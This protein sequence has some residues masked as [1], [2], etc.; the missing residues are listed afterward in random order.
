MVWAILLCWA[1]LVLP[2][3]ADTAFFYRITRDQPLVEALQWIEHSSAKNSLQIL[4]TRPVRI[5]FKNMRELGHGYKDYDA[6]AYI[7]NEGQLLLFINEKHRQ[8]PPQ[9]LA[10]LMSHELLH[11][12]T[13]NSIQEEV[14]AWQQEGQTWQEMLQQC[15]ELQKIPLRQHPLVDRLNAIMALQQHQ[16]L[17]K[18]V[19]T[20]MAYQTLPPHSPGY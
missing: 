8:A 20:H 3:F 2:V 6:L 1:G 16:Q 10:A 12:D 13:E 14:I 4:Q 17:E 15:P 19:Q 11:N 7:S 9:A 5:L 18:T